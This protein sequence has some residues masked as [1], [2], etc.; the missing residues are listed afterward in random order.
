MYHPARS[1]LAP[2]AYS[3]TKFPQWKITYALYV[4]NYRLAKG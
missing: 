4:K 2:Q 3:V 1:T